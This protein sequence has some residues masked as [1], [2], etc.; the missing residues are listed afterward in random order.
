[1]SVQLADAVYVAVTGNPGTG[2]VTLGSRVT[3]FFPASSLSDGVQYY[4][5]LLDV[6]G[7]GV[8]NGGREIGYG[9]YTASGTT[10][11]RD[12]VESSVSSSGTVSTSKINFSF[13][14]QR[15]MVAATAAHS[16][17]GQ[18][19]SSATIASIS[20]AARVRASNIAGGDGASITSFTDISGNSIGFSGTG[21]LKTGGNGINGQNVL[22]FNGS[23]NAYSS[24]SGG[25][26]LTGD[27][28]FAAVCKFNGL[29]VF[30]DVISF[31]DS[32]T[33][34]KRRSMIIYNSNSFYFIGQSADVNS[35]YSV[36]SA[37]AYFLEIVYVSGTNTISM[38][39]NG[40][41][42]A[43][44]SA[45]LV[46]FS[47]AGLE[48]GQSPGAGEFLNGDVAE[49]FWIG[50]ALSASQRS[51]VLAY[52]SSQY[53]IGSFTAGQ[54]LPVFTGSQQL[55][56][57]VVYEIDAGV[58]VGSTAPLLTGGTNI[59]PNNM[60]IVSC[61][62]S[63]ASQAVGSE[64][65]FV[66]DWASQN[67]VYVY[68]QNAS[69]FS[70]VRF[71]RPISGE[72]LGAIGAA[73]VSTFPWGGPN[74]SCYVEASNFHDSNKFGDWR[75]VQTKAG[76]SALLRGRIRDDTK[77][78]EDYDDTAA[79]PSVDGPTAGLVCLRGKPV[80]AVADN[81]TLNTNI[82][83]GATHCGLVVVK[84]ATN[85]KCAVYRLENTTLTLVSA[86]SEFSTSTPARVMRLSR[87]DLPA[88][89]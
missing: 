45:S 54:Y 22:R 59:S 82:T 71:G 69:G 86:D 10:F 62:G 60:A 16:F 20:W 40:S 61:Y 9:T 37:T 26:G 27:F 7:S 76:S 78:I 11:S 39:V 41:I 67:T 4:Y 79:E 89:V 28:Y 52:V 15:L 74:N 55:G 1:M 12:S 49:A 21:T 30:Q 50:T 43:T 81:G 68:N 23:S 57:S 35:N 51:L 6:D 29:G 64:H 63:F 2:T 25:A 80:T 75:V 85:S 36:S 66:N 53:G 46:S 8:P 32:G 47:S 34:G 38:Y 73:P 42:V 18:G 65:S 24:S 87:L 17:T 14:T 48:I 58:V 83:T 19:G 70:A 31:G 5:A 84:D 33:T 13:G 3:G 88:F 77:A 56:S 44:G 72:E